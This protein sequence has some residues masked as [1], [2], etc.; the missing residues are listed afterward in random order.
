MVFFRYL[1][2]Q[3]SQGEV[4]GYPNH[5]SLEPWTYW[6]LTITS[7]RNGG[8]DPR[9]I[10]EAGGWAGIGA[11]KLA[12]NS[13][14]AQPLAGRGSPPP[15]PLLPLVQWRLTRFA[16]THPVSQTG[17]EK[18][19]RQS[20]SFRC[21]KIQQPDL[22]PKLLIWRAGEKIAKFS[23]LSLSKGWAFWRPAG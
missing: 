9:I 16:M 14:S 23:L 7:A 5:R 10:S 11:E 22:W 1:R 20:L 17:G 21:E 12:Q 4:G 13:A 15:L 2:E 3:R 8:R 19:A 6:S 18:Q